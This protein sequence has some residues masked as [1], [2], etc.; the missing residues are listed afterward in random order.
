MKFNIVCSGNETGELSVFLSYSVTYNINVTKITCISMPYRLNIF[1]MSFF[2][3][4]IPFS[5]IFK[6]C[7]K[8]FS[9]R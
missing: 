1:L 9:S 5:S 8:Y 7:K 6:K 3:H 2:F 4:E